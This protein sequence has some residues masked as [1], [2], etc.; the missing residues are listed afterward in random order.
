MQ[1]HVLVLLAAQTAPPPLACHEN[2]A[3][4]TLDHPRGWTVST[5]G[6]RGM[7]VR[8]PCG[9]S[10]VQVQGLAAAGQDTP[11]LLRAG[12]K[13]AS[14]QLPCAEPGAVQTTGAGATA[15]ATFHSA[16]GPMR[17]AILCSAPNRTNRPGRWKFPAAGAR[18]AAWC[19]G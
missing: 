1:F 8:P 7:K 3:G 6:K 11:S 12:L 19:A 13:S 18:K 15:S 14:A 4:F 2:P 10:I 9:S 5:P 17:A 16:G